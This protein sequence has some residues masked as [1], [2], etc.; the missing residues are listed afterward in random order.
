M[1]ITNWLHL[2]QKCIMT[3]P[4]QEKAWQ[5]KHFLSKWTVPLNTRYQIKV[6]KAKRDRTPQE[7]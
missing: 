7:G 1:I 2:S 6:K 4:L 3:I 5:L